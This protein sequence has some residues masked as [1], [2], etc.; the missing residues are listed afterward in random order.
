MCPPRTRYMEFL[1]NEEIDASNTTF[2]SCVF[3]NCR[4]KFDTSY[5]PIFW[6][7]VLDQN[8]SEQSPEVVDLL[9]K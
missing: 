4:L 2:F 9:T 1:S 3:E 7:C 6:G 8:T 5:P